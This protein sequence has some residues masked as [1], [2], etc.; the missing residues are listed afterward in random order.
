MSYHYIKS[1]AITFL[2]PLLVLFLI[3]ISLGLYIARLPFYAHTMALIAIL[4]G[5]YSLFVE[6]F[7]SLRARHYALD[8][9]AILAIIVALLTGDLIV[10][11]IIALMLSTGR[12][13]E[14][15]G[16]NQ[17]KN[18]LTRLIDRIPHEVLLFKD[19]QVGH[20]VKIDSVK[21]GDTIFIRKG[22]V[23]PLDGVL[24]S[25]HGYTD[26]SSLTGE[27]YF[28]DKIKG[29]YLRSGT[30]NRG[31]PIVVRVEKV[32][33]DSTYQKIMKLVQN[34]QVER[35]PLVR[36][37][38]KYS[39]VFTILTLAIATTT[40]YFSQSLNQVL[41][42]LVI[43][44]PCPLILATP[45]ALLGGVNAAAKKRIIIKKLAS[46]ELLSRVTA[47][48]FDKT[49]TITLG[50]PQ[51]VEVVITD[52]SVS[53]KEILAIALAIER[54]SLHPLAKAITTYAHNK[55]VVQ[56]T[57]VHVK[58][59][60]GVG[61]E[62]VV[63]ERR[64]V[65]R[66]IDDGKGMQIELIENKKRLAIFSF[67]DE[68]KEDSR[69]IISDLL[70]LGHHLYIY[71]GDKQE[72]AQKVVQKLDFPIEI[73]A[74]CTPE[75]KQRGVEELKRKGYITAMVGDGIN[76]APALALAHV[77]MVYSNEEQTAASEAADVVFLGNEFTL[78]RDSLAISK[79]TVHIAL[80][81]I[82]WGIGISIFGMLLASIGLI[83]PLL[84]AFI[85]E[86]IDVA[87]ILNALRASK[88]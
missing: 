26:E 35:A 88:S 28:I 39:T 1:L 49:G 27:P 4:L 14:E 18:S 61:I 79:R 77:G 38:D 56:K 54:N 83:P 11:S 48:I 81:S 41:A 60:V 50:K 42:V 58:E 3:L 51:L 69:S 47:L 24:E 63:D 33:K 86:A 6:T 43:A 19:R 15:Y 10:G 8:Y 76:D 64:Y 21:V 32:G 20:R 25:D 65:L 74:E 17:A 59:T 13:L 73:K 52:T 72:A 40:Y 67:E 75:E 55:N 53:E 16:V 57:A 22:E 2:L 34:A 46:L 12:T 29:D 7:R 82:W 62:G 66:K 44:T 68:L 84:G 45:I 78:V 71:T 80:Q 70:T 5:S 85:Q 30:I 9:I 31:D 36:L 23:I 37:A 87:V